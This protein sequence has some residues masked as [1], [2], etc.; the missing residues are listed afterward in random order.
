MNC[1]IRLQVNDIIMATMNSR[2]VR[3]VGGSGD[4]RD[5]GGQ[6]CP[7]CGELVPRG[8]ECAECGAVSSPRSKD[9][10]FGTCLN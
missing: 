1:A 2:H 10:G 3:S 5:P 9:E 8:W 4:A 7:N 6:Y